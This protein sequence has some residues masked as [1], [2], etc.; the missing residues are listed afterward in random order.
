MISTAKALQKPRLLFAAT[1]ERKPYWRRFRL[2][3]ILLLVVLAAWAALEVVY[4]RGGVE[5]D[6][7]TLDIGR[8]AAVFVAGLLLVRVLVHFWH[9]RTRRDEQIRIYDQGFSWLREGEAH[10]YSWGKLVTIREAGHGIYLG[11]R[12]LVQWGTHRLTMADKEQFVFKPYHGDMRAFIRAVRPY[13]ADVTGTRMGRILRQE[14]PVRLHPQLVAWPGGLAV[15]KKELHWSLL[16]VDRE[17]DRLVIRLLNEKNGK[18]KMLRR[19][20]VSRV[21]NVQGFVEL[22]TTTIEH[23]R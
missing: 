4:M 14:K 8:L 19:F 11:K 22:A 3:V 20:P 18:Y 21:D 5:I 2:A 16:D 9:W 17:G 6:A 1:I 15:G 7:N 10:K 23:H 13:A 12:P